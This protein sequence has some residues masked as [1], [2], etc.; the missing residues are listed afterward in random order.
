MEA[1]VSFLE[2]LEEG[3]RTMAQSKGDGA[4]MLQ[5]RPQASGAHCLHSRQRTASSPLLAVWYP[6]ARSLR[7]D[8]SS[9]PF[10]LTVLWAPFICQCSHPLKVTWPLSPSPPPSH[11]LKAMAVITRPTLSGLL[12]DHTNLSSVAHS[13]SLQ[14]LLSD[15][16]SRSFL[17]SPTCDF[18]FVLAWF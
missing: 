1:P 5:P 9:K 7:S 12:P 17:P 14:A 13:T 6:G 3:F 15:T 18:R 2:I 8:C 4:A 16:A 11:V 10:T